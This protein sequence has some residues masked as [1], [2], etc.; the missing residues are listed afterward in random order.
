MSNDLD[1]KIQKLNLEPG[2]V[3]VFS[4]PAFLTVE[5]SRQVRAYIQERLRAWGMDEERYILLN[6]LELSVLHQT[7]K[8]DRVSD[9]LRF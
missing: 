1:V 2:D 7:D 9:H 6:G 5:Q 4:C 8:P 3:L